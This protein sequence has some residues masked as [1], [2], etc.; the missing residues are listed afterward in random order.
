MNNYDV[1]LR[2]GMKDGKIVEITEVESGLACD[3]VCPLCGGRLEAVKG[4]KRAWHFRHYGEECNLI[5]AQQTAIHILAKEIIAEEKAFWIP[6]YAIERSDLKKEYEL[7]DIPE[8]YLEDYI[9]QS[10]RLKCDSV[11]L[12]SKISDIV[13]DVIVCAD[14]KQYI[15]EIAVTHFINDDKKRKIVEIGIPTV[16]VD[17][18]RYVNILDIRKT[19]RDILINFNIDDKNWIYNPEKEEKLKKL[20]GEIRKK[21]SL[22]KKVEIKESTPIKQTNF[23]LKEIYEREKHIANSPKIL[24][25]LRKNYVDKV[26]RL[27]ENDKVIEK[28]QFYK[29]MKGNLP[30]FVDIP[31]T[32]EIIFECDRRIWQTQ[33]YDKFIYGGEK[34]F[35][36]G[37]IE[38]SIERT[39]Y[40]TLYYSNG[41]RVVEHVIE[42]YLSYMI[43]MG[44]LKYSDDGKYITCKFNKA[45][46]GLKRNVKNLE[47]AVNSVDNYAGNVNELIREELEKLKW[48]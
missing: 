45:D 38:K 24:D 20:K 40:N 30:F 31:V 6:G 17:L 39:R 4:E 42:T 11:V 33:I 32:D 15:I 23:G 18:S 28:L 44:L 22:K 2:F 13:P 48:R 35:T 25:D 37:D 21:C 34:I 16:E 7:Y 36:V 1:K 27:R 41:M 47:K 26:K 43:Y 8:D 12:E 46:E 5:N 10:R 14:G 3:C 29:K 19:L 9:V